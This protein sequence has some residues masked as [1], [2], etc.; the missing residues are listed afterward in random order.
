M[1]GCKTSTRPA[2]AAEAEEK[3]K[4]IYSEVKNTRAPC[5][6]THG[7][8]L[9]MNHFS[10]DAFELFVGDIFIDMRGTEEFDWYDMAYRFNGGSDGGRDVLLHN[11][12]DCVGAIQCKRYTRNIPLDM[13][14]TELTK[15]FL[16]ASF[17]TTM[18]PRD[19]DNEFHWY[20]ASSGGIT[21]QGMEFLMSWGKTHLEKYRDELN[22]AAETV[23][24]GN[25]YLLTRPELTNLTGKELCDRI[26]PRL[27]KTRLKPLRNIELSKFALA[28]PGI[29]DAYYQLRPVVTGDCAEIITQIREFMKVSRHSHDDNLVAQDIVSVFIPHKLLN[30]EKLNLAFLPAS[31]QD[32]LCALEELLLTRCYTSFTSD[33]IVI[34]AGATS[35]QPADYKPISQLLQRTP[36]PVILVVGCG[37]VKGDQLLHWQDNDDLILTET[38]R[39]ILPKKDYQ[40]GWCWTRLTAQSMQCHALIGNVVSDPDTLFGTKQICIMFEDAHFWPALGGDFF[41]GWEPARSLLHKL[42][43]ITSDKNKEHKNIIALCTDEANP[44]AGISKAMA[45]FQ[46]L[47]HRG[48]LTLLLCHNREPNFGT[49][50][51]SMTGVFPAKNQSRVLMATRNETLEGAILRSTQTIL[52]LMT[53]N[54]LNS[55]AEIGTVELY[56]LSDNTLVDDP[57]ALITELIN[58]I[59]S[60]NNAVPGNILPLAVDA[61]NTQY[62]ADEGHSASLLVHHSL[63]HLMPYSDVD[64]DS[65][66]ASSDKLALLAELNSFLLQDNNL[67]WQTRIAQTGTIRWDL[68]ENPIHIVAL[69]DEKVFYEFIENQIADWMSEPGEHPYLHVL[70]SARGDSPEKQIHPEDYPRNNVSRVAVSQSK[71]ICD[72]KVTR[73][74]GISS[75]NTLDGLY[76]RKAERQELHA[77]LMKIRKM[78][79]E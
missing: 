71:D 46:F 17:N 5:Y 48:Q 47:S 70:A 75:L 42:Y 1:K 44:R 66:D 38:E 59:R 12:G 30:G 51:R 49:S 56:H 27:I 10:D 50:L 41:C 57:P 19:Q 23:R 37:K 60:S 76:G 69:K 11:Q 20:L 16:H 54:L 21:S 64:P 78:A 65:L 61:I 7:T 31:D 55:V 8:L 35:F 68:P 34:V 67:E 14:L 36:H 22:H 73:K 29:L 9:P 62:P 52:A 39:N 2:N 53:L 26:W 72:Y 3:I 79:N 28:L 45:N 43:L 40:A 58:I 4:A 6:S 63:A 77:F 32:A 24:N 18:L 25:D 74:A 33:P 15:Y 13:V